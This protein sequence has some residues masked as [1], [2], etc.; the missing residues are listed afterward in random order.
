MQHNGFALAP[1]MKKVNG[2]HGVGSVSYTHLFC[3]NA[4][5]GLVFL[6]VLWLPASWAQFT[7]RVYRDNIYPAL[8]L[9]CLLYTSRCV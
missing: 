1:H 2:A 4:A 8:V 9:L 5:S 6:A 7:L 3:T